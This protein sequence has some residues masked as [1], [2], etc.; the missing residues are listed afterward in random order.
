MPNRQESSG[1]DLNTNKK[2]TK[3]HNIGSTYTTEE[4]YVDFMQLMVGLSMLCHGDVE[5]RIRLCFDMFD[6]DGSGFLEINELVTLATALYQISSHSQTSTM[7]SNL[8]HQ[9]H[10]HSIGSKNRDRLTHKVVHTQAKSLK[11]RYS[12][13]FLTLTSS[14][15]VYTKKSTESAEREPVKIPSMALNKRS[16]LPTAV[17]T[18]SVSNPSNKKQENLGRIN[19]WINWNQSKSPTLPSCNSKGLQEPLDS[20]IE[21]CIVDSRVEAFVRRLMRMDIVGDKR[22]SFEE[23]RQGALTDPDILRCLQTNARDTSLSKVEYARKMGLV[24][25]DDKTGLPNDTSTYSQT[26]IQKLWRWWGKSSEERQIVEFRPRGQRSR[27][28]SVFS[29]IPEGFLEFLSKDLHLLPDQAQDEPPNDRSL[30]ATLQAKQ[31]LDEKKGKLRTNTYIYCW[32]VGAVLCVLTFFTF[33][34]GLNNLYLSRI[35]DSMYH[36]FDFVLTHVKSISLAAVLEHAIH[37]SSRQCAAIISFLCFAI[38]F[39]M[40]QQ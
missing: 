29:L 6:A 33:F 39:V 5:D 38:A 20:I 4:Q 27:R 17:L 23:W 14:E 35:L 13:S 21:Q 16:S 15:G 37:I 19:R 40:G 1:K 31:D 2:F 18:N 8:K 26:W 22:L 7:P 12:T 30:N 25:F 24:G 28:N 9:P 36:A 34:D 11:R 32:I 10:S 3:S